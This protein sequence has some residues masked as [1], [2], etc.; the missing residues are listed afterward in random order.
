MSNLNYLV[1]EH[2]HRT[3]RCAVKRFEELL[4]LYDK[5]VPVGGVYFAKAKKLE[6]LKESGYD[7]SEEE[8]EINDSVWS[9]ETVVG[10]YKVT[11]RIFYP[12]GSTDQQRYF[13]VLTRLDSGRS[14]LAQKGFYDYVWEQKQLANTEVIA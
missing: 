12:I 13:L 2:I 4:E 1:I 9:F 10:G 8:I 11:G 14:I 5:E 3:R 6:R 7:V